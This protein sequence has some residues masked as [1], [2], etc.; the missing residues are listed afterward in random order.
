MIALLLF[1]L[2]LPQPAPDPHLIARWDSTTSATVSWHQTARGCLYRE[3]A[4]GETVFVGCYD[5]P[6]DYRVTFGHQGP[7]SGDLRPQS[8]DI[9]RLVTGGHT[10][11]AA[12]VGRALYFPVFRG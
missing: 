3:S 2:L 1:L 10:Y 8:H 7:L 6:G 4:I 9:Y 5:Q 11:P 12:L